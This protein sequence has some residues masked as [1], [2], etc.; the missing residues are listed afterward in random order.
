MKINTST[1]C[2]IR[3][4]LYLA[5]ASKSVSSSKLST[6]IGVSSQYLLQI[7]AKLRDA[8][9]IAVT[10]GPNGGYTLCK[11]PNQIS[12]YDVI[13][14]MQKQIRKQKQDVDEEDLTEFQILDKVYTYVDIVL[15]ELL[16]SIT[17]DRLL[18]QSID[19]WF[20]APCL[21]NSKDIQK[22]YQNKK[23]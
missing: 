14:V 3:L 8:D 16:K 17:M 12:L 1:D 10:Y 18:T 5:K 7:G 13:V 9:L 23:D 4:I 22:D 2:A 21:M 6:A 19:K 20:L 15:Y 11:L